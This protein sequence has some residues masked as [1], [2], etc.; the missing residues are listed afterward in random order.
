MYSVCLDKECTFKPRLVTKESKLTQSVL[1]D[2]VSQD[3]TTPGKSPIP[4]TN[5]ESGII[6]SGNTSL[7]FERLS[8]IAAKRANLHVSHSGLLT[9]D[10]NVDPKTG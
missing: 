1:Q 5:N 9:P 3:R 7:V 6:A 2:C 8:H 10:E 4:H